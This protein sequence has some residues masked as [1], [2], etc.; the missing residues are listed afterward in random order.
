[1][2]T[3]RRVPFYIVDVF[4]DQPLAGNPLAVIAEA[5]RLSEAEM[6]KIAREFNQSE[7]TFLLPPTHAAADWR[8]RSFTPAGHEV[9][10]AGHNALGAWWWLA[11]SGKLG[12]GETGGRFT[13]EIGS[14]LLVVNV[15]CD[16][17]GLTSIGMMQSAPVFGKTYSNVSELAAA[18]GI[19]VL[20][21]NEQ[22][23]VQVVSTGAAHM[24]VPLRSRAAVDNASPNAEHLAA[25]LR[26]A[27]GEGCYLFSLDPVSS[28]ATAYARFFNPTVGIVE[29]AATG[30]AAGPLTCLLTA[31]GLLLDSA[32]IEQ[33]H[34]MGR[35]SLIHVSVSAERVQISGR[36]FIT[37]QG[38]LRLPQLATAQ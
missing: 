18:L 13:Q 16:Q 28:D 3:V 6:R 29:D 20:D 9:F 22:L 14:D 24:L 15:A 33:G 25:V 17:G 7:T 38:I 36:G 10:G 8:L 26:T 5:E 12:L 31:H 37:A 1:M 4:S 34:A 21:F 19:A 11:E 35:P 23:P 2:D 27:G 30:T 32:I